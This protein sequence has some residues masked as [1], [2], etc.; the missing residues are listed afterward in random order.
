MVIYVYF[1]IIGYCIGY[2]NE[3]ILVGGFKYI[4]GILFMGVDFGGELEVELVIFEQDLGF[5]LLQ[6][7]CEC[8]VD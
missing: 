6:Y 2:V 5:D 8:E 4:D 1:D 3:L 7:V